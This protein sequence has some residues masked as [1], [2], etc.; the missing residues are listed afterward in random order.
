MADA[1]RAAGLVAERALAVLKGR[2]A[3]SAVWSMVRS[4]RYFLEVSPV[5]RFNREPPDSDEVESSTV[6]RL[7]VEVFGNE[8]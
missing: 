4:R 2:G 8:G 1:A 3:E 6:R 7:W 5:A